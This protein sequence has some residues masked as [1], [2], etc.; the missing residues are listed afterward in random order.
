MKTS[1]KISLGVVI[2]SCVLSMV[3]P[4]TA[5]AAT[6]PSLGDAATFGILSDTFT[7][8]SA[9]TDIVGDLGYTT[10]SGGGSHTLTGSTYIGGGVGDAF[11]QQAGIDQNAALNTGPN[12][13]NSQSCT[14]TF[15]SGAINLSTDTT[16][17]QIGVYTPGVYCVT[18]AA[19][20]GTAGITLNGSGTYIFRSTGALDTA[21]NS[22]VYSAGASSCNVFWTPGAGTTLGA[23]STFIGT[24]IDAAGITVGSTVAWIGRALAFGGTVTTD[25]DTITSTCAVGTAAVPSSGSGQQ[26]GN[27]NIVKTVIN[28]SGGTKT[29][30]DFPLFV[31]GTP[32]V[33]GVTNSFEAPAPVYAVTETGN[34]NYT[35][36]FSGGCDSDGRIGLSPG[37]NRFCIITNDDI[38]PPAPVVPPLIDLVKTANPLS[39]PSGPGPVTYTYTLRNIGTVPVTDITMV[40]D[41]CSPVLLV[42][43]DTN[44]NAALEMN[45]TWTYRCSTTL[46]VTHTNTIVATGWANGISTT[47]IASATVVVG[48]SIVPPLIHIVKIPSVP[49][50]LSSGGAVTYTYIVTNPGT[51]PLSNVSISDNKCTGLPGRVVGHPGDLNKNNLLESNESWVFSCK[52]NLTKTTTNIGTASGSAN[53]LTATDFALATVVV[54]SP[55]LP[56]TGFPLFEGNTFWSVLTLID[57]IVLLGMLGYFVS[58][59]YRA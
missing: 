37:D 31:N 55:K 18:G 44:A 23:N 14:F 29:V 4:I 25:T 56:N 54:A 24:V 16:H 21:D 52:T 38:G 58:R 48:E 22:I 45:E 50:L 1:K 32:V 36:S 43:G 28:D 42:S 27:I 19:T 9:V 59:R 57:T 41:S 6:T 13:L 5:L 26:Y 10:L 20:V 33:S 2:A 40:G 53:G 7:R 12:N 3:G 49:T 51:E 8:N 11:Y 47:D 30:A 46:S 15:A 39:L 34:A 17:G 35:Q